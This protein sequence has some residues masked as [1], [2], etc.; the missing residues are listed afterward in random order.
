LPVYWVGILCNRFRASVVKQFIYSPQSIYPWIFS[1]FNFITCTSILQWSRPL[2]FPV[3]SYS[4][5]PCRSC[6]ETGS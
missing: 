1:H 6:W 4:G 5:W 2:F 3:H